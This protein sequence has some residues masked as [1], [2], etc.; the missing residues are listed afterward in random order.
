MD[1]TAMNPQQTCELLK[2]NSGAGSV[3]ANLLRHMLHDQRIRWALESGQTPSGPK[4]TVP[5]GYAAWQRDIQAWVAAGMR[6]D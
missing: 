1:Y 4:P 2:R 5:G 3:D 6:C